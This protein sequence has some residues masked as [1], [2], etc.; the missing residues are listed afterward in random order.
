MSK[1]RDCTNGNHTDCQADGARALRPAGRCGR[2]PCDCPCHDPRRGYSGACADGEHSA[3]KMDGCTWPGHL[4]T[5]EAVADPA[6]RPMWEEESGRPWKG[7]AWRVTLRCEGREMVAPFYMGEAL[8]GPP[9]AAEVLEC[10]AA[11]AS[12]VEN[13]E[14]DELVGEMPYSRARQ[15]VEAVEAS[16]AALRD[17]LGEHFA[18]V[19]FPGSTD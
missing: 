18:A 12:Y 16:T 7:T 9:T 11:D 17:L 1:S 4:V 13:D 3:C 10:L 15:I 14:L 5:A 6:G 2:V 19:V 8:T